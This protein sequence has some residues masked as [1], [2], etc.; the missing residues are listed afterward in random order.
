MQ[1]GLPLTDLM[2]RHHDKDVAHEGMRAL[3]SLCAHALTLS[4]DA[5]DWKWKET[6]A[7]RQRQGDCEASLIMTIPRGDL[8]PGGT[9]RVL[10]WVA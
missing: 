3:D 2:A 6:V 5:L 8:H 1:S 4:Q 7:L 10:A 9:H